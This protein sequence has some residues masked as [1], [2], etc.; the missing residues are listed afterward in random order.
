MSVD[1]CPGWSTKNKFSKVWLFKLYFSTSASFSQVLFLLNLWG[2]RGDYY[3]PC[4]KMRP[5]RLKEVRCLPSSHRRAVHF[6][7]A[8]RFFL[9]S[10]D[11]PSLWLIPWK[12]DSS[13]SKN[14]ATEKRIN[15]MDGKTGMCSPNS[16]Q[17]GQFLCLSKE[18]K[19]KKWKT[20]KPHWNAQD[21]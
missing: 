13:T 11:S 1:C 17:R 20:K 12:W 14:H 19:N 16:E 5:P 15:G 7:S 21:L 18:L 6:L 8:R 3:P 4:F 10:G 9:Q 2:R